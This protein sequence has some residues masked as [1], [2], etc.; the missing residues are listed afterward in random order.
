MSKI[1]ELVDKYYI[2]ILE[3]EYYLSMSNRGKITS[4][5]IPK[6]N[7]EL[8]SKIY[9][10][11]GEY[12]ERDYM[13][14]RLINGDLKTELSK[15]FEKDKDEMRQYFKICDTVWD[16]F[17]LILE[18]DL[19]EHYKDLG[20]NIDD[21]KIKEEISD[22]VFDISSTTELDPKIYSNDTLKFQKIVSKFSEIEDDYLKLNKEEVSKEEEEVLE[23]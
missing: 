12:Y 7:K 4:I 9:K 21:D 20:K 5:E 10:A 11:M 2:A 17:Y 19:T 15:I 8:F 18:S 22:I 1:S 13:P 3:Y 14:W 6:D 16:D 23:K